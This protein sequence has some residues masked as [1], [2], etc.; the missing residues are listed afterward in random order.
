MFFKNIFLIMFFFACYNHHTAHFIWLCKFMS[1][2]LVWSS[3]NRS[4]TPGVLRL[5]NNYTGIKAKVKEIHH[6]VQFIKKMCALYTY[7]AQTMLI[8]GSLKEKFPWAVHSSWITQNHIILLWLICSRNIILE[9]H[10]YREM[11][12]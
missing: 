11:S 10:S 9:L 5:W 6:N 7:K 2:N 3:A 4:L 1:S 8:R 12:T